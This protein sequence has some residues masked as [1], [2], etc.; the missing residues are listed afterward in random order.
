MPLWGSSAMRQSWDASHCALTPKFWRGSRAKTTASIVHFTI[1]TYI[2]VAS[3]AVY[4]SRRPL[5]NFL[6]SHN[7]HAF[8][9]GHPLFRHLMFRHASRS[10]YHHLCHHVSCVPGPAVRILSYHAHGTVT[11]IRDFFFFFCS[12]CCCCMF[13]LPLAAA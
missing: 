1:I 3:H 2:V 8:S 13:P 4:Q 7:Q 6:F 9:S 12:C 11:C 5:A 10:R